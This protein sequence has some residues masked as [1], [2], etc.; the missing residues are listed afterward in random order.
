MSF[1]VAA[2]SL[3]RRKVLISKSLRQFSLLPVPGP[4]PANGKVQLLLC[5]KQLGSS[6]FFF[7]LFFLCGRRGG[8]AI[9]FFC[10]KIGCVC[11]PDKP[12]RMP[13]VLFCSNARWSSFFSLPLTRAGSS[14]ASGAPLQFL[15]TRAGALALPALQGHHLSPTGKSSLW[16]RARCIFP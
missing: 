13:L 4:P 8:G 12:V 5:A 1:R 10:Q 7:F 14:A 16:G 2:V 3:A 15:R 11:S 6:G 9:F